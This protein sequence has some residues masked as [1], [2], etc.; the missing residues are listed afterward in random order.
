MKS[1]LTHQG[2]L[3]ED[4]FCHFIQLFLVCSDDHLPGNT[5]GDSVIPWASHLSQAAF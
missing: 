4:Q 3:L 5:R 1:Q 2:L